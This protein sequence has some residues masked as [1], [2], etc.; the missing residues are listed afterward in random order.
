MYDISLN[1]SK[2]IKLIHLKI[3]NSYFQAGSGLK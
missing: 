1:K 3:Q 2:Q